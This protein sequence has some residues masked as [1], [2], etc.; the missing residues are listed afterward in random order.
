MNPFYSKNT[1]TAILMVLLA[2]FQAN[3]QCPPGAVTLT[4]QVE[5]DNFIVKYPNCTEISENLTISGAGITNLEGLRNLRT[6]KAQTNIVHNTDLT[7]LNGLRNVKNADRIWIANNAVL[8]SL[9]GFTSLENVGERLYVGANPNLVQIGIFNNLKTCK[10]ITVDGNPQLPSFDGFPAITTVDDIDI[11]NNPKLQSIAPLTTLTKLNGFLNIESNAIL[12]G[13]SG[14]SNLT[15]LGGGLKIQNNPLLVHLNG[16]SNLVSAGGSIY[17]EGNKVLN[18]ITGLQKINPS[19]ISGDGLVLKNN[20]ALSFC[21]LPNFCTYLSGSGKRDISGNLANCA[22]EQAVINACCRLDPPQNITT[23]NANNCQVNNGSVTF[24]ISATCPMSVYYSLNG[25]NWA[26]TNNKTVTISNL[27]PRSYFLY[28]AKQDING[29]PDFNTLQYGFFTVGANTS[30][31]GSI[32]V[33]CP[34]DITLP[35]STTNKMDIITPQFYGICG[36]TNTK[37][38]KLEVIRPDGTST[39]VDPYVA[40]STPYTLTP[41]QEGSYQVKWTITGKS[42]NTTVSKTCT[43]II[44]SKKKANAVYKSQLCNSSPIK[45]TTCGSGITV[46]QVQVSGMNTIDYAYGLKNINIDASFP[47]KFNGIINLI[48]PDGTKY[49]LTNGTDFPRFDGSKQPFNVSFTTCIS[50]ANPHVADN[51]NFVPYNTYR[52][53]KTID[54]I[55]YSN[56]NPN[57]IWALEICSSNTTAWNLNCFELEFGELCPELLDMTIVGSCDPTK[58][59]SISVSLSQIKGSYCDDLENDGTLNYRMT[60]DNIGDVTLQPN[61]QSLKIEAVPG[62]YTVKFGRYWKDSKGQPQWHCDKPYIIVIPVSDNQK[63]QISGCSANQTIQLGSNGTVEYTSKHP[64]SVTDNCGVKTTGLNIRYLNGATNTAGKIIETAN[65]TPGSSHKVNIKGAG[66]VE[67]EYWA[68]DQANNTA[69]CKYTVTVLGD[70]CANDRIR[71]VFTSC[72][73]SQIAVLDNNDK[74]IVIVTDPYFLDNCAVTLE[75]V[76][77]FY[78]YG[79]HDELG[80]TYREFNSIDQGKSYT[81]EIYKEGVVLFKYTIIDAAGNTNYC[82]SYIRTVKTQNVC[83]NDVTP[84]V[85]TNCRGDITLTLDANGKAILDLKDP[86]VFDNCLISSLALSI[87]CTFGVTVFNETSLNYPSFSPGS[88]FRYDFAGAGNA[89][90]VY[91]AADQNGNIATCQFKVTTVTNGDNALFNLGMACASPGVKTYIPV[92][93]NRFNKI[94]AFSFDA[95]FANTKGIKFLGLENAGITN[96]SSNILSN[97]T[98][99]I[100]WDEPAGNDISLADN[101]KLFDIIVEA[102]NNYITPTQLLGRDLVLLSSGS[103]NGKING[104]DI[105]IAFNADPKG[106]IRSATHVTQSDVKINLLSGLNLIGNTT[107]TANG[108]YSFTKTNYTNRVQPTKND[109]WRKGVDIIDVAKIRRHF[110][111]TALLD[112]NYKILAADVNKDGKINVLDVAYTNRLFLHKINEFPGNTSWRYIPEALGTNFDPLNVNINEFI[113]LNDPSVDD[114]KLNFVSV[115]VGDV[116]NSALLRRG[117]DI[118]TRSVLT[119]NIALPDTTVTTGKNIRI[120][121]KISGVDSI[122]LMSM[123]VDF[124]YSQLELKGIESTLMPGFGTG[125]YNDLGDK[126]LIGWDHPQAGS[127]SANGI[128]MTLVFD[129]K[130]TLGTSPLSLS[131]INMYSKDF[132]KININAQNGSLTYGTSSTEGWIANTFIKAYPNPFTSSIDVIA[133]LPQAEDYTLDIY[134]VNGKHIFTKNVD[135][136]HYNRPVTLD[137]FT[138]SGVYFIHFKSASISE[139]IK[140]VYIP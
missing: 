45:A 62:T 138:Q 24:G 86:D 127:I 9:N 136:S 50:P 105:C 15:N 99:R 126:V 34:A 101:F 104:A 109:E 23:T 134:D 80:R 65:F 48:S 124:D 92:T 46:A 53:R 118:E 132:S 89:Y 5:I 66:T 21:N 75:K 16:L 64:T 98:L 25:I 97:G 68:T 63:P 49:E 114:S 81:Y 30:G 102:D 11:K 70:P 10:F 73:T 71:P 116:D 28:I 55:N 129:T 95:Y 82:Y 43:Q 140:V 76:E 77:L 19:K 131:E 39:V 38:S 88:E 3:A 41:K 59:G 106:I 26:I 54:G 1:F 78:L 58:K 115:K 67:F 4:S 85:M 36:V 139:N 135:R 7:S 90:F 20:P 125:N 37:I 103:N 33:N 128:L 6:L 112:D 13:L 72:P 74:A 107:T 56:L 96:V 111:Q 137:N 2:F 100:S 84:P 60:I 133:S 18:D 87:N 93:V 47:G 14:L 52:P 119:V 110:L 57:G 94:G 117:D 121:V 51:I 44:N 40:P 130:K 42:G 123:I 35:F 29:L 61:Q 12:T 31:N 27:I 69:I 8:S 32:Q 91:T 17:I 120:P 122:S 22:N 79:T 108:N 113:N 83:N